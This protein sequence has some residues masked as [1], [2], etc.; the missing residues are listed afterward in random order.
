MTAAPD[1]QHARALA[2]GM[3]EETFAA[4][5]ERQMPDA[6]K[7][8][9]AHFLVDTGRGFPSAQRQVDG[10]LRALASRPGRVLRPIG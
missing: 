10:I 3:S 9:D 4:I 1:V 5:R 7:R 2:P 6:E 8:A